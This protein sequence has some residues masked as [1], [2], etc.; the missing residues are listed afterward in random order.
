M[1]R[2]GSVHQSLA[3]PDLG[4][5]SLNI[6]GTHYCS[7]RTAHKWSYECLFDLFSYEKGVFIQYNTELRAFVYLSNIPSPAWKTAVALV[8]STLSGGSL[9]HSTRL[10]WLLI[11]WPK[12]PWWTVTSTS[13]MS[14]SRPIRIQH[15]IGSRVLIGCSAS[16]PLVLRPSVRGQSQGQNLPVT[17][18]HHCLIRSA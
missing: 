15:A 17:W 5:L 14:V 4:I 8:Q 13:P 10:D 2:I 16:G 9:C 11:S 3:R 1:R 12:P 6:H 7:V 18:R